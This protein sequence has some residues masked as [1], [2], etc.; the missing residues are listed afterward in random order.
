MT[1]ESLGCQVNNENDK[2]MYTLLGALCLVFS[3]MI[4]TMV[5]SKHDVFGIGNQS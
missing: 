4:S 1:K 3:L 2:N 5:L